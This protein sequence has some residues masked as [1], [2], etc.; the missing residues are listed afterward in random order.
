MTNYFKAL[1]MLV[2]LWIT[3]SLVAV[4]VPERT[5]QNKPPKHDIWPS[6]HLFCRCIRQST[7]CRQIFMEMSHFHGMGRGRSGHQTKLWRFIM[8][9]PWTSQLQIRPWWNKET[10]GVQ[11]GTA[12]EVAHKNLI[13]RVT[14]YGEE[15]KKVHRSEYPRI[16]AITF[17]EAAKTTFS[18]AML[19]DWVKLERQQGT[20]SIYLNTL[21]E[22]LPYMSN[23]Q[24]FHYLRDQVYPSL[25]RILTETGMHRITADKMTANAVRSIA[26]MLELLPEQQSQQAT[27]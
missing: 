20:L 4:S 13:A 19:R 18:P 1:P 2:A 10:D 15:T 22:A 7:L 27:R 26:K 12:A 8:Q 3:Q 11:D 24:Q 17:Q 16:P 21:S 25:F 5:S 23:D 9:K 14:Q 6:N